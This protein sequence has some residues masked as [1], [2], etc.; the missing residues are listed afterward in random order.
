MIEN[1]KNKNIFIDTAP[2]IYFIERDEVIFQKLDDFFEAN[3]K[4][5]FQV[6]TS[7]ITFSEVLV[8]PVSS[9]DQETIKEYHSRFL[10]SPGFS[11]LGRDSEVAMECAVIR[12]KYGFKTPDALI[13]ATA[14][15][16]GAD[17][18]L[19]NDLRLKNFKD[20]PVITIDEL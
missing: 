9:N 1:F 16:S 8:K 10:D 15:T 14:L 2:I 12:S 19:T 18:F 11:T 3:E 7:I 17:Y 13:L 4:G 5:E 6:Q 20:I